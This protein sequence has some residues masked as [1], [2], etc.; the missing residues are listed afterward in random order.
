M[1]T[2]PREARTANGGGMLRTVKIHGYRSLNEVHLLNL[3]PRTVLIGANG[4]GKSN[5]LSFLRLVPFLATQSLRRF[6]AEAGGASAMLHYG[7]KVT[8]AVTFQLEFEDDESWKAY[9][10]ELAYAAG[11]TLYFADERVGARMGSADHYNWEALGVGHQESNLALD[12]ISPTVKAVRGLIRRMNYFH[13]H[14]T[15]RESPMRAT[16]RVEDAQYLRSY[17]SNL[18]AYLYALRAAES[19]S[20]RA[21]WKRI[22]GLVRLVAPF[23]KEL[24]PHVDGLN[25]PSSKLNSNET[26]LG[27]KARLDWTDRRDE[28]FGPHQLSDG[29]LRTIALFTAL[30]QPTD[31]LPKFASFDEPELGLHPA[32]LK[33]FAELTK[34]VSSRCQTLLATQSAPFLN[35]LDAT[36]VR[37]AE[38]GPN[39]T[40]FRQLDAA[41]L[42]EWQKDYSLAE[43]FDMNLLGGRP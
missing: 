4:A 9:A 42:A 39:G 36:E 20:A 35:Y 40:T 7:P 5:L 23:I 24:T 43:L 18:A 14:D 29:T 25:D 10:A 22:S 31:R 32:A 19:E 41:S 28:T 11:D 13:F 16:S 8:Q 15:S 12:S 27:G 26:V 30:A 34:S 21:S 37:V 17:G 2:R 6:V 33:V 1:V 38:L 3:G